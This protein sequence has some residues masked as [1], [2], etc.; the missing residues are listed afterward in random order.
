MFPGFHQA[1][2]HPDRWRSGVLTLRRYRAGGEDGRLKGDE[3]QYADGREEKRGPGGTRI[4]G[5]HD[6]ENATTGPG[7]Q[8]RL[9]VEEIPLQS[10]PTE[11]GSGSRGDAE[12]AEKALILLRLCGP[13]DSA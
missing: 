12:S 2:P 7:F 4:T 11:V 1:T 10:L 3:D 9:R 13:R 8:V 6:P 5:W